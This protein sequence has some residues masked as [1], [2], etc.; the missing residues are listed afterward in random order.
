MIK[1][2][3]IVIAAMCISPL[4][5]VVIKDAS[6]GQTAAVDS[7]RRLATFAITESQ[8]EDAA[9][10]GNAYAWVTPVIHNTADGVTLIL[11]K[12]T[13]PISELHIEKMWVSVTTNAG[14]IAHF[15]TSEVT[16][17][18]TTVTGVN[19]NTQSSNSAD[20]TAVHSETNNVQG[21]IIW[22]TFPEAGES[23]IVEFDGAIILGQ[24]SSFAIDL[25]SG[26]LRS[27]V[28]IWGH[29]PN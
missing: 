2:I 27:Q 13:N 5:A 20:A 7:D 25:V 9:E 12:N 22:H 21:N 16:P 24:N 15:P 8:F 26:T 11:I 18:G 19:L 4:G 6:T 17:T 1:L 29:Y 3:G 23:E 28:T 10:D 14:I